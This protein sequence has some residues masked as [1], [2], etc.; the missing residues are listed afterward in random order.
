VRRPASAVIFDLDGTLVDSEPLYAESDA[1]FLDSWGIRLAQEE[2]AALVGIGTRDF[3]L[4]LEERHPASLLHDLAMEERTRL[5]DEAYIAWASSRLKPFASTAGLAAELARRGLP[6]AV[7]S[8]SSPAAVEA[9]LAMA[10]LRGLFD[11]VLSATGVAR[12]KPFPDIFLEAARRLGSTPSSC[13]VIEDSRPGIMA[14]RRAGMACVAL[15]PPGPGH[16]DFALADL[17]LPGGPE[18]LDAA[19]LV[20]ALEEG[21]FIRAAAFRA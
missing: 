4:H 20:A 13:L 8:G 15:P 1:A 19:G 6:L 17:V 3:F 12:G 10:G 5:K 16:P 18:A 21:G 2:V 11:H 14:A 7:A 9:M